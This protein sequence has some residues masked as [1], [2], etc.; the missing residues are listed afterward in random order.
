MTSHQFLMLFGCLFSSQTQI[1]GFISLSIHN[2]SRCYM[3]NAEYPLRYKYP[4]LR[5]IT[6]YIKLLYLYRFF[7][8]L[9]ALQYASSGLSIRFFSTQSQT[10]GMHRLEEKMADSNYPLLPT[11][12]T[13]CTNL[14][15][16]AHVYYTRGMANHKVFLI[17]DWL[18]F[19]YQKKLRTDITVT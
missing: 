1:C 11:W 12:A 8:N 19:C 17:N 14:H 7:L 18:C 10:A 15:A 16:N 6:I 4:W 3:A 13:D 5:I 9:S 2:L